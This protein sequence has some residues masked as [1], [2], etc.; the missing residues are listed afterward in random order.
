MK[1]AFFFF[2]FMNFVLWQLLWYSNVYLLVNYNTIKLL[3]MYI[4]EREVCIHCAIFRGKNPHTGKVSHVV[5][6]IFHFKIFFARNEKWKKQRGFSYS[7]SMAN[8]EYL[9]LCPYGDFCLW[10]SHSGFEL[11]LCLIFQ[12]IVDHCTFFK[13]AQKMPLSAPQL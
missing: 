2:A 5:F 7:K 10:K 6:F 1:L 3:P 4:A 9:R 8:F 12:K 13:R 11:T